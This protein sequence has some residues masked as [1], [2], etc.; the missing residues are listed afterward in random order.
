MIKTVSQVEVE[1][2]GTDIGVDELLLHTSNQETFR[3]KER[4][5]LLFHH[6]GPVPTGKKHFLSI[7]PKK[8]FQILNGVTSDCLT[9]VEKS[10]SACWHMWQ[11]G[12]SIDLTSLEGVAYLNTVG[13]RS[14][15]PD[16]ETR[17]VIRKVKFWLTKPTGVSIS[18]ICP[19]NETLYMLAYTAEVAKLRPAGRM[20]PSEGFLRPPVCWIVNAL[21]SLLNIHFVETP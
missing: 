14:P 17:L 6:C 10:L 2:R 5:L 1:I 9:F 11:L 7:L 19:D 13:S 20:R 3:I 16:N 12:T 21:P 4:S 15:D 18:G 8:Y